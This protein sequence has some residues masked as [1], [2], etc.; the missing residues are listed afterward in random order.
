MSCQSTPRKMNPSKT[1]KADGN[2]TAV[3]PLAE[4]MRLLGLN[5]LQLHT[6]RK[7]CDRT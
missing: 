1:E 4:R 2:A 5:V 3:E 7:T 6:G